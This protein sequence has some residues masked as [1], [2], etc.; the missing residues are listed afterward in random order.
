MNSLGKSKVRFSC[1][2]LAVA[3]ALLTCFTHEIM[4]VRDH[5]RHRPFTLA[6]SSGFFGFFAH[7][8]LSLA[9]HEV[10]LRPSRVTG[11][12]AGAV[13]AGAWALDLPLHELRSL[14]VELKREKFWDPSF[15]FGLL[16]G[17]RL[18][19]LLR[20]V[21]SS[22]SQTLPY[23]ISTFALATRR[24]A[25]F[26]QGDLPRLIR[27][28]CAVPLMFHPVEVAGRLYWDGGILDKAAVASVS[29]G[30]V[31]LAHYLP[32]QGLQ[33]AYESRSAL[34]KLRRSHLVISPV[35]LPQVGPFKLELGQR[36]IDLAYAN[37]HETL[38]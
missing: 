8:G 5:L 3:T 12:S 17:E 20:E 13:L 23:S 34:S 27:A 4:K 18:E 16:K 7:Y 38:N 33:S 9:L 10:G 19:G 11:S 31:V 14:L 37:A 32:G 28:S 36:C 26:D 30:E 1:A 2:R 21:F 35:D 25:T 15:G 6:L 24:T 22:R 29:A